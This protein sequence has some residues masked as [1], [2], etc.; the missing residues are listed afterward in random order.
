TRRARPLPSQGTSTV[1]LTR[2]AIHRPLLALTVLVA[3][4][5]F[6][7]VAFLGLGL[8]QSPTIKTPIVT[9]QIQYT[10][11]SAE[12]VEQ[13]V[14]RPVEGAIAP[15]SD[16]DTLTTVSSDSGAVLTV[17]WKEHVSVDVAATDVQQKVQSAR[18]DIPAE[19]EEPTYLKVDLNDVPILYLALSSDGRASAVDLFRAAD[20]LVRRRIE[21]VDGVGRVKL[22]GGREPE[23]QVRV[24]P[25]R[26]WAYGLGCADGVGALQRQYVTA[27]G[28]EVRSRPGA[29]GYGTGLRVESRQTTVGQM[30]DL[31]VV[32]R[33]GFSTELRN[34]ATVFLDG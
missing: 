25:E 31:P 18:R 12:T 7:V 14:T 21:Q 13:Q 22:V 32:A 9:V 34:V 11:A 26:L 33:D 23:V 16:I 6:G 10:G 20:D 30:D 2:L 17:E 29:G 1:Q 24:E 15:P 8:E 5:V 4:V 28:G 3:V 19:I 27:A